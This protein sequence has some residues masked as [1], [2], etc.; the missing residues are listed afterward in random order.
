M[1]IR[2]MH[3]I[4]IYTKPTLYLWIMIVITSVH[5]WKA[6]EDLINVTFMVCASWCVTVYVMMMCR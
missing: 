1:Y 5:K 6:T 4:I 3:I 2:V